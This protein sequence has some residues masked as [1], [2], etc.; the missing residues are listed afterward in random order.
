MGTKKITLNELRSLVKQIIKEETEPEIESLNDYLN[1]VGRENLPKPKYSIGDRVLMDM[2]DG[3]QEELTIKKISYYKSPK[4]K[5]SYSY[6]TKE[7]SKTEPNMIHL[8]DDII[9]KL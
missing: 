5:F 3:S 6:R 1:R 4:S 7:Y 9:K 8:E 2:G